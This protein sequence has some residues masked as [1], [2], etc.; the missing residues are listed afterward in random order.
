MFGTIA[1]AVAPLITKLATN[2]LE[3]VGEAVAQKGKEKVE[4]MLGV[5]LEKEAQSPEGIK[6]LKELQEQKNTELK[7]LLEDKQSLDRQVTKRWEADSGS[8]SFLSKNIRPMTLVY[9]LLAFTLFGILAGLGVEVPAIYAEGL[10]DFIYI[11]VPAY[12]GLRTIDK[13]KGKTK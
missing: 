7:M 5:D 3:T 10:R 8:E 1:A 4:D 13:R 9:L 2:G 12:F 6:K 11:A